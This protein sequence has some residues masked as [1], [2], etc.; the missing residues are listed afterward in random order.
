MKRKHKYCGYHR[1]ERTEYC[2]KC[3]S[4]VCPKCVCYQHIHHKIIPKD[5]DDFVNIRITDNKNCKEVPEYTS[6]IKSDTL[7]YAGHSDA[8]FRVYDPYTKCKFDLSV[9]FKTKGEDRAWLGPSII[10]A[11]S[12]FLVQVYLK[13]WLY[14][15][16]CFYHVNLIPPISVWEMPIIE[17]TPIS[18]W[19]MPIIE[20]SATEEIDLRLFSLVCVRNQYVYL[21]GPVIGLKY[22]ISEKKL[23]RAPIPRNYQP[24]FN[25]PTV[26]NDRYIV[27]LQCYPLLETNS[28]SIFVQIFDI[29]DEEKGWINAGMVKGKEENYEEEHPCRDVFWEHEPTLYFTEGL[30]LTHISNDSVLIAHNNNEFWELTLNDYK[31]RRCGKIGHNTQRGPIVWYK[32]NAYMRDCKGVKSISY[33][34]RTKDKLVKGGKDGIAISVNVPDERIIEKHAFTFNPYLQQ[35]TTS[36]VYFSAYQEIS[37]DFEVNIH[38]ICR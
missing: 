28:L 4:Y 8:L 26:V 3:K 25:N 20:R 21:F 1:I 32:G 13:D 18:V 35:Q 7:V 31:I 23:V 12:L 14:N 2:L 37:Q 10:A 16:A 29:L 5:C 33:I 36:R 6:L 15:H 22:I 19:E 27:A 11:G 38:I 30:L 9:K 34:K 24:F 17:R